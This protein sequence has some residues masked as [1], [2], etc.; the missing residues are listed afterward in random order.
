[1]DLSTSSRA[2]EPPILLIYIL[3]YNNL[4]PVVEVYKKC[5][6][7]P[8]IAVVVVVVVVPNLLMLS[9]IDKTCIWVHIRQE[10]IH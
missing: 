1:M 3:L 9:R 2:S 6:L 5:R 10:W 7:N 4:L 8:N